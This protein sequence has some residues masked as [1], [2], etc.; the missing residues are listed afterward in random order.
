[1]TNKYYVNKIKIGGSMVT[2]KSM[3]SGAAGEYHK[4]D[5]YH[6]DVSG[7]WGGKLSEKLELS[8]EVKE[9]DFKKL[10]GKDR[11]R[12][13]HDFTF[14]MPKSASIAMYLSSE[15]KEKIMDSHEQ[16]INKTLDYME[17]NL[18]EY[19]TKKGGIIEHH[20]TYKMLYSKF[21]HMFSRDLDPQTHTHVF[22]HNQVY[23][24]AGKKYALT[25]DKLFRN[26]YLLG[27]VYRN[28][29]DKLLQEK[30]IKTEVTEKNNG[31]YEIS[32]IPKE[33]RDFFSK[34][35]NGI[36]K[37]IKKRGWNADNLKVN[38]QISSETKK[39]KQRV[40]EKSMVDIIKAWKAQFSEN[41]IKLENIGSIK[42]F[43]KINIESIH[44]IFDKETKKAFEKSM[45]ISETHYKKALLKTGLGLGVTVDDV[46]NYIKLKSNELIQTKA[47]SQKYTL[48]PYTP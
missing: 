31:F 10:V 25:T 45:A 2:A 12:A 16:A 4:K 18:L 5:T 46:D 6:L 38:N 41:G 33:Q 20:D 48:Y 19:R 28:E 39:S 43:E 11:K 7:E 37:E 22:I 17:K 14:S 44:K 13:G 27:H 9:K 36:L 42:D 15:L 47:Y 24:K 8:G 32:G 34:R 21:D 1:M 30:G 26:K 23:D 40:N 35:Q 3:S 29:M